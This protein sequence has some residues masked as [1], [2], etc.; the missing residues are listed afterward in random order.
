MYE[1]RVNVRMF[2]C[3]RH[4]IASV[5]M[6]RQMLSRVCRRTDNYF[7]ALSLPVRVVFFTI[8]IR[9]LIH[10]STIDTYAPAG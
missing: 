5:P 9:N 10:P 6:I 2:S 4:A 7:V 8:R 1:T 3:E